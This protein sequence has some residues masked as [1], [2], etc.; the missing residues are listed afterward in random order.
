MR[1]ETLTVYLSDDAARLI[2]RSVAAVR[3]DVAMHRLRPSMRTPRGVNVFTI[4]DITR[5][6]EEREARRG[7]AT[8][9]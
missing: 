7:D 3:K 4:E 6:L 9:R 2:D 1:D 5:Y 8:A